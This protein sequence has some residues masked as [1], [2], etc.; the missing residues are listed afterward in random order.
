MTWK[1]LLIDVEF[2]KSSDECGQLQTNWTHH[3]LGLMYLSAYAK[4][5]L[6]DIEIKVFHMLLRIRDSNGVKNLNLYILK[7]FFRVG[8][9]IHEA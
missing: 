7:V 1:I 5:H 9:Q 6:Q 2:D 8:T 4:E 3:P